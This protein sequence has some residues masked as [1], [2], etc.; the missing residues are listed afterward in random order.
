LGLN[1]FEIC[2][3]FLILGDGAA[4]WVKELEKLDKY[5]DSVNSQ[6]PV[7]SEYCKEQEQKKKKEKKKYLI[8]IIIGVIGAVIFK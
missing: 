2:R 8:S 7:I 5:A 3:F 4:M 6:I 1:F